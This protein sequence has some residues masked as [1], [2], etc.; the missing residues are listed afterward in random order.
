MGDLKV[1]KL[2]RRSSFLPL[3]FSPLLGLKPPATLSSRLIKRNSAPFSELSAVDPCSSGVLGLVREGL[4]A[5][6]VKD[7]VACSTAGVV[8]TLAR[9]SLTLANRPPQPQPQQPLPQQL[10]KPQLLKPQ[11]LKP[12]LLKPQLQKPQLLKPQL[13]KPQL[14]KPQLLKPQLLKPQQLQKPQR[15]LKLQ[16]LQKPQQL[17]LSK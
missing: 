1:L 8:P 3:Q 17:L 4:V 10:L 12:Q 11:L 14:L 5:C 2:L 6:V 16:L 9:R 15:L 7:T 13:Q